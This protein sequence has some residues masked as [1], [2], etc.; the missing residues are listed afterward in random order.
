MPHI[1][2]ASAHRVRVS[3]RVRIRD[4]VKDRVRLRVGLGLRLGL[5]IAFR[6]CGAKTE[7]TLTSW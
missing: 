3:G 1:L 2:N 5:M 6:Q 4:A 7:E